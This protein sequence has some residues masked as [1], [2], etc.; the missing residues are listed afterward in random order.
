MVAGAGGE[1]GV[2]GFKGRAFAKAED[3]GSGF[4]LYLA[5]CPT[6]GWN[7]R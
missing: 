6:I 5:N 3:F 4:G 7:S 2:V 1:G